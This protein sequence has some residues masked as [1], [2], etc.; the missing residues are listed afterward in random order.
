MSAIYATRL[1]F[2]QANGPDVMLTVEGD[3]FYAR[4]ETD[5]GYTTVYDDA[6]GLYCYAA[7]H[8]GRLISSG[9]SI[10]APP[11]MGIEP[12]LRDEPD[13]HNDKFDQR[14]QQA[15]PLDMVGS[16]VPEVFGPNK[17]L[18][19]GRQLNEGPVRGLTILVNFQ[20]VKTPIPADAVA[21][22]LN[23]ENY[24]VNGNYCSVR[25]YFRLMST[26]K[27]DYQNTVVGPITLSR[28]RD[29]YIANPLMAEALN[30]VVDMGVDLSQFDSK[31]AGI[32]DAVSFLYA[33][34][35]VYKDWLWPHNF[36]LNWSSNGYKT[37]L[38]QI[39]ALGSNAGE[40][41]IGTFCHESGHMLC[42]FPDLYD[43]GKRDGDF[44]LSAGLGNYCL[45]S[46][47]NHANEG[48]TPIAICAYL[49]YLAGWCSNVID[50]KP[51]GTFHAAHGAYDTVFF[52]PGAT[53]NEYFLIENR[54]QLGLD[55]HLPAGGLAVYHC[56]INGTN[57]HEA[58]SPARH[59]QCALLQADGR[60][61]L[62]Q[63]KNQGD[64]SDLFTLASGEIAN[65]TSTPSTRL[66][67]GKDSGLRISDVGVV[68][69]D[70]AFRVNG[71]H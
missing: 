55:A 71:P 32:L 58:G 10:A 40:L 60:F 36:S 16:P 9:D 39:S 14:F 42:R 33:G 29:Y 12:H 49:R 8:N 56:D 26:D 61:D 25:D 7:L 46:S 62:E 65:A 15:R 13:V 38:Y 57:E 1:P 64:A 22:M 5:D 44:G 19:E 6:R 53:K 43:Y 47:G 51:G 35:V 17:G 67:N 4:Y 18:L 54:S 70:I 37:G 27:L 20:D 23:A 63:N 48:R 69:E 21:A 45:M 24:H 50:I 52:F 3:E 30:T 31:Q 2:P 59:Y 66:W 11:S 34:N 41:V 28:K 68:G